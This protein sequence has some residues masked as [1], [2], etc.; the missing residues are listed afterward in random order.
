MKNITVTLD[1][2]IYRQARIKAASMGTSVSA[3][4]RQFLVQ[5]ASGESENER[6]KREERALR[7][8]IPMFTA[9]N[10]SSRDEAYD[11]HALS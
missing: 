9:G 3:M 8:A 7:E 6:L 5:T 10:R 1:D 4:V 2:E 11:R